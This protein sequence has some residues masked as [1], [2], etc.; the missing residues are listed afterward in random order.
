MVNMDQRKIVFKLKLQ[1]SV[2]N[3]ISKNPQRKYN[4]MVVGNKK[5]DV[6]FS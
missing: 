3:K 5:K 2:V 1:K 4:P 6:L